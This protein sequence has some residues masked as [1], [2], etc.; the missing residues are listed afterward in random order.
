MVYEIAPPD[1]APTS[2]CG[3]TSLLVRYEPALQPKSQEKTQPSDPA[4]GVHLVPRELEFSSRYFPFVFGPRAIPGADS[5]HWLLKQLQ[6]F[7]TKTESTNAQ[8]V[9]ERQN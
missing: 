3:G 9:A 7:V 6:N 1:D 2:A 8:C 5:V 4:H